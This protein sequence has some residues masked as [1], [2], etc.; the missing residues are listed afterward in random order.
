ME[1]P[2][3]SFFHNH[4]ATPDDKFVNEFSDVFGI[5]LPHSNAKWYEHMLSAQF[6]TFIFKVLAFDDYLNDNDPDY[7]SAKCTYKDQTSISMKKYI[8]IKY[9]D[10]AVRMV[11]YLFDSEFDKPFN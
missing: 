5:W 4:I 10:R 2:R 6:H 3:A 11:T 7:N 1:K 9:G 8:E